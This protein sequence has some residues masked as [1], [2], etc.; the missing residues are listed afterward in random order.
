VEDAA[1]GAQALVDQ[2]LANPK[3][4]IIRGGSSGGYTVLNALIR[5]PGLFKAGI[6]LYPVSNLFALEMETHKFEASYNSK[7]IGTLPKAAQRFHDWSPIFHADKIRDALAI[8]QG[9]KD[10][11]V[12]PAH[13]EEL[14]GQLRKNR[15]PHIYKL[16]E[17]EGHGFRKNETIA[18]YLKITEKF[19]QK[20]V[21]FAP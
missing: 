2:E 18:E 1:G 20:N 12:L 19:L 6:C 3:Q 17:D 5:Y 13:T 21:L 14:I 4:L 8:F 9:G 7:L 10:R 16:F 11:V 15:V